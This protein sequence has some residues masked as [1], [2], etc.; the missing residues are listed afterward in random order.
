MFQTDQLERPGLNPIIYLN[1]ANHA[2]LAVSMLKDTLKFD[3]VELIKN[4]T[5]QDVLDKIS[6]LKDRSDKFEQNHQPQTVILLCVVWVGFTLR[7]YN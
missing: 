7:G 4:P 5:K 2:E 1:S 6:T 3:T